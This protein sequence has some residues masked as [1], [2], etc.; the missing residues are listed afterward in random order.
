MMMRITR[1]A[2]LAGAAATLATPVLSQR[3]SDR[4]ITII[5]PFSAGSGPDILARLAGEELRSRWGQAVVVDNRVGASGNLGAAAASRSAPDGHTLLLYVNTIL[6]NAALSRNL[7]FD[8][9]KG[10]QP[11]IEFAR[12]SLAL[13][14]HNSQ[15]FPDTKAFI[16]ASI[17]K[18]DDIRFGSPGRGTPHH[19]AMELFKLRTGAKLSHVPYSGTG[20]VV[21]DFIGGHVQSMFIPLHVGLTHAKAGLIRL[22]AVASEKR[23]SLAPDVPTLVEQGIS[24]AEVDLWY[25]LSA[26]AGT[27]TEITERFNSVL[28]DVLKDQRIRASLI[29][30]GLEAMGGTSK[31]FAALIEKDLPYWTSVVQS[32]GITAEN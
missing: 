14:V 23:S 27:S 20:G 18:P 22:L 21:N 1:R 7:Q 8:P 3:L 31:A 6:M 16:A 30:Q 12:G 28:N 17:A 25:G 10:F 26:P 9:V 19:L 13:A 2:A 11:I 5:V 4:P 32:A 29:G 24:N 15:P